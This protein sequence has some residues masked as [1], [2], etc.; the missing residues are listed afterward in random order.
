[1]NRKIHA[2]S[3]D[4]SKW[5]EKIAQPV[6]TLQLFITNRCNLRCKG[7]FMAHKLGPQEM[8]LDVYKNYVL[9]NLRLGIEKVILLGGE[10]TLH[11]DLPKMINFNNHHGLKT[12]IYTNGARLGI[13][14]KTNLRNTKVRISVYGLNDS[15]KP[16]LALKKPNIPVMFTY[17]L[18]R[19]NIHG[20]M[21][22]V[23]A[24]EKY[25]G[26]TSFFISSI[27]DIA[28]TQDY[29]KDTEETL[30]FGEYFEIVQN[31]INI[32]DGQ[33]E[34]H[35]SRRGIIETEATHPKVNCCRFGN[36]FPDGE[37]IICP[38]DISKRITADKLMFGKRHCN[39]NSECL[40]RKIVLERI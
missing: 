5:R 17:M 3:F 18:R 23:K 22:V 19:D 32:Y 21:E 30:P 4:T 28:V 34:I 1:M 11:N 26:C 14:E 27:R 31:F 40:L 35:I 38:F 6:N 7:C 33:M 36:I 25:F 20:L 29:W 39:K 24:V 16:L 13:L 12:T 9:E 10:P 37:K 15:E 2:L 8:S